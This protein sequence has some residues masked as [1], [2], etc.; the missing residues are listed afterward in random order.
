M[1]NNQKDMDFYRRHLPHIQPIGGLFFVTFCLYGSIPYPKLQQI[2]KQYEAQTNLKFDDKTEE[3]QNKINA[4]KKYIKNIDE[5]LTEK[6]SGPHYMKD[7]KIAGIVTETLRYWDNKQLEMYCYCIMSN[8]VHMVV[9]LYDETESENPKYLHQIMHS[10]K[11]Y[12]ANEANKNLN[13]QEQFWMNES[14]DYLVRNREELGRIIEYIL[15][16]PVKARLCKNRKDWKWTY[17][18]DCYNEFM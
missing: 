2:Q 5:L 8:H 6:K 7:G 14:F 16:N 17:I 11:S 12:S 4:R 3:K 1:K 13:R 9:R 15:D 10:I 18:K